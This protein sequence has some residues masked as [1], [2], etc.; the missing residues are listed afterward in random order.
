MVGLQ[1]ADVSI[2]LSSRDVVVRHTIGNEVRDVV[3][4][5]NL[6]GLSEFSRLE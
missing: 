2:F 3:G 5:S 1:E 4:A 6:S